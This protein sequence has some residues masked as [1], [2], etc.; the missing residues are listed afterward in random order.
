MNLPKYS[1]CLERA[2][3]ILCSS[4]LTPE[5]SFPSQSAT[6][7]RLVAGCL[8]KTYFLQ[9]RKTFFFLHKIEISGVYFSVYWSHNEKQ[10][11][12]YQK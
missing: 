4:N 3:V 1:C 5:A 9:G 6:G 10:V 11:I 2:A 8:F 7:R 12:Y